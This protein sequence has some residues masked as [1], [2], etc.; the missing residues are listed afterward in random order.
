LL[1]LRE[2]EKTFPKIDQII[3][4]SLGLPVKATMPH[5]NRR[6]E[7]KPSDLEISVLKH[8]GHGSPKR[9]KAKAKEKFNKLFDPI[10]AE[11]PSEL[12]Q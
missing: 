12:I 2:A 10:D 4:Q 9:T 1:E 11:S 6:A 7:Y 3:D 8:S 5:R